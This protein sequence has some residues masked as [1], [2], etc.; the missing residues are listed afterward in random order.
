[1]LR[2]I[3]CIS[4]QHDLRLVLLA[5]ILCMFAC[6][7]AFGMIMRAHGSEPRMRIFWLFAAGTVAGCG[8]WGTHFV[9]MLAFRPG[10]P[11]AHDAGLT[12]LSVIVAAALCSLGFALAL[13][14]RGAALGGALTGAAISAMHYAGMTAVRISADAHWDLGYVVAS[15]LIGVALSAAAMQVAFKSRSFSGYVLGTLLFTLAICGMHFTGM[16]AVTYVPNPLI[17]IPAAVLDPIALAMA[18]AAGAVLIVALGLIGVIVDNHLVR[19]ANEEAVRLRAHIH[20][21]EATKAQLE[22]TTSNLA[23]AL[24]SADTAN[25]A[26]SEF[27]ATMSHELRTPLNAIIGF[28][29]VMLNEVFGSLGHVRYREYL[30]SIRG[31][32]THL[33]GLIN[34]VLDM[35][36]LDAG[37][38]VLSR[39]ELKIADLI[40]DCV[41]M[42]TL[43]AEGADISL[44]EDVEPWL[45]PVHLDRR[46]IR[47]VLV[48]LLTNAVKFTPAEGTVRISAY[49]RGDNLAIEVSDTGIGMAAHDI[50]KALERFGQLDSRLSRKYEGTGLGLPLAKLL[51]ELHGGRLEL[52]SAPGSGTK[53]TVILP[54]TAISSKRQVAA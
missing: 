43:Q 18:V 37:E 16:S 10:L 44:I 7:T 19:R 40:A 49:R 36:R 33:L 12:I 39:E 14:P 9:A 21:L 1:M 47:Q 26:K 5:G 54:Q 17:V 4:D 52:E 25:K 11:V 24:V 15:V 3:N 30:E 29:E 41:R 34:D 42:I 20:E 35:S 46:R 8:I 6:G 51:I 23:A 45:P 32:G 28:S 27:L 13:R 38:L 53:A 2:V 31:S 50:P 22:D 48:N